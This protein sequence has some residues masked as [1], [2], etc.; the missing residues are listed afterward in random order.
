MITKK[1]KERIKTTIKQFNKR[2]EIIETVKSNV[3]LKKVINTGKFNF[4][5]AAQHTQWLE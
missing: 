3:D 5:Q 4:E 2:A 1:D